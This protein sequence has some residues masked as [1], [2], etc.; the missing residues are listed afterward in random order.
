MRK[1]FYHWRDKHHVTHILDGADLLWCDIDG[2][3]TH[4]ESNSKGPPT[5]LLCVVV[6]E[7]FLRECAP[8]L[9]RGNGTA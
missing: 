9:L 3:R 1:R 4:K 2:L 5:C 7:T 6:F 8:I